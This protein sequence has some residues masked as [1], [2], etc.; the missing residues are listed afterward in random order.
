MLPIHKGILTA[1]FEEDWVINKTLKEEIHTYTD[2]FAQ[3][4]ERENKMK[5]Y[6]WCYI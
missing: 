3:N 5:T 4:L 6:I 1:K 2:T